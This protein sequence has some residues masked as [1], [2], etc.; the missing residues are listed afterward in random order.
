MTSVVLQT[1]EI[2]RKSKQY[3]I[4]LSESNR[5]KIED[6]L[7]SMSDECEIKSAR[8]SPRALVALAELAAGARSSSDRE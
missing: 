7:R 5:S 1:F 3:K 8:L 4:L 2:A 6:A